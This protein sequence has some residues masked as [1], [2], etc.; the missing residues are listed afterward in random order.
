MIFTSALSDWARAV[1]DAERLAHMTWDEFC[2][3]VDQAFQ[4]WFDSLSARGKTAQHEAKIEIQRLIE[5]YAGNN[6]LRRKK[7]R[8]HINDLVRDAFD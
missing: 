7:C 3:T 1:Q 2:T 4:D 8:E 5:C 6:L